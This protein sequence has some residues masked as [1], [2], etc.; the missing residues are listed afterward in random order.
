MRQVVVL[1]GGLEN[2]ISSLSVFSNDVLKWREMVDVRAFRRDGFFVSLPF[3]VSGCLAIHSSSFSCACSRCCNGS[4]DRSLVENPFHLTRYSFFP[5][6]V[7]SPSMFSTSH[8]STPSSLTI[9]NGLTPV[10]SLTR[11]R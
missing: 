1:I 2:M 6:T 3:V 11:L 5:S 9:G 4:H 7:L 10:S 8:S